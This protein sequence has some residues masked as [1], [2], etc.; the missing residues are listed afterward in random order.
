MPGAKD[1]RP[2]TSLLRQRLGHQSIL[3]MDQDAVASRD[4]QLAVLTAAMA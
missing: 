3:D 4:R 2:D 1:A